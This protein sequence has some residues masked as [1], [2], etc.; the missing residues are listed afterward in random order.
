MREFAEKVYE[1]K[2]Q[3]LV[4]VTCD[5]CKKK[6]P[7]GK[8]GW[9]CARDG[10]DWSKSDYD[11]SSTCIVMEDGNTYPE[12]SDFERT[13]VDLCPDCFRK[14]LLPWLASQGCTI[15]RKDIN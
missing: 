1:R 4:S 2:V 8:S 6:Y 7:P 9:D 13:T 5:L 10:V 11:I 12:G 3:S 15:T 14:K